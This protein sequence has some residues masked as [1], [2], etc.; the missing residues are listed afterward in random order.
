MA[1]FDPKN[2]YRQKKVAQ[3]I[4]TCHLVPFGVTSLIK[5]LV[6]RNFNFLIFFR[7]G[8]I[9]GYPKFW[10]NFQK[11]SKKMPRVRQKSLKV[12]NIKLTAQI[13]LETVVLGLRPRKLVPTASLS[14]LVY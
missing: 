13:G 9:L 3:K 11:I 1:I 6:L 14:V 4:P 5:K 7:G 2:L 10:K 8:Q 12:L